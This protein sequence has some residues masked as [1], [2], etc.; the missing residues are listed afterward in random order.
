MSSLNI[1]LTRNVQ[2]ARLKTASYFLAFRR[3]WLNATG[4]KRTLDR[5]RCDR[6]N[7][8]RN[9]RIRS[10][11]YYSSRESCLKH[12]I[13]G[14]NGVSYNKLEDTLRLFLRECPFYLKIWFVEI[15][16]CAIEELLYRGGLCFSSLKDST[17]L[18]FHSLSCISLQILRSF[19]VIII[20]LKCRIEWNKENRCKCSTVGESSVRERSR[21]A[22]RRVS[23]SDH[24]HFKR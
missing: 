5:L 16:L 10:S 8:S 14:L 3:R 20:R 22:N 24:S 17:I 9:A 23:S 13:V 7:W 2:L 19:Y 6:S 1:S 21:S 18:L 12:D 11:K 4:S 15:K